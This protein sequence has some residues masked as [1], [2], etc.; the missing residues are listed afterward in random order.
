MC[1]SDLPG[2]KADAL[3]RMAARGALLHM[4]QDSYSASHAA[5][6]IGEFPSEAGP[7]TAQISCLFPRHFYQYDKQNPSVHGKADRPPVKATSCASINEADD[8]V[9][10]SAVT[11]W[12]LRPESGVS[13]EDYIAYLK[14]RVFGPDMTS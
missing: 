9:T 1:S 7:Y 14:A 2:E 12:S 11:L 10:A 3:A 5:R 4:I 8:A 6:T 13:A